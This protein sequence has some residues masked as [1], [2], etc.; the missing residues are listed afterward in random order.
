MIG[1]TAF[2]LMMALIIRAIAALD[3]CYDGR[4]AAIIIL[5]KWARRA[6]LGGSWGHTQHR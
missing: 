2:A 3:G 4:R 6:D 5:Q 1:N